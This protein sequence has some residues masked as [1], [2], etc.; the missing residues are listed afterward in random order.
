MK[1]IFLDMKFHA[2]WSWRLCI[3]LVA[4][5][6]WF[7]SQ[8]YLGSRLP[9]QG[10]LQTFA[11]TVLTDGDFLLSTTRGVNDYFHAHAGAVNVLLIVSSAFIDL[12]GLF[13]FVRTILGP[14]IRPFV[15]LFIVFVLRQIAQWLVLLPNPVG[16]IWHDPGFPTFLVTYDVSND[17]FF[18]GHTALAVYGAI[19]LLRTKK[20]SWI[21][22][23]YAIVLLEI[24]T[25]I[26][27]RGHYTMDIFT[28]IIVAILATFLADKLCDRF[29]PHLKN[30]L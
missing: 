25:M 16:K 26:F 5:F 19:Q 3:V 30:N 17:L 7:L 21:F 23:G 1:N 4:L 10:E 13:I 11:S 27:L 2:G 29:R 22:I 9:V 6:G 14:T 20:R 15:G 28:G 8:S 12:L 18:S 24:S